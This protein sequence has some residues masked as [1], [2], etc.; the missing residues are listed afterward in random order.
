LEPTL[1]VIGLNHRTAPV[2]MR[3]RFW[4]SE[5]RRYE[6]LRQLKSA[7][8]IEEVVVLSTRCRTEFWLWASDATLA[9]NSLLHFLSLEQGL[10]LSEWEHFYRLLDESALSHC[11]RVVCGLDSIALGDLQIVTQV[12]AA[13]EQARTVGASGRF[14]NA[15]LEKAFCVARQVRSETAIAG[16]AVSI[17]TAALDLA[18]NIFGSLEG[19]NVLLL[20]T[21]EMSELSVRQ[22]VERGVG[23][24]VVIDP[25][26]VRAQKL[27]EK[28]GGTAATPA[29]RW[30][31]MLSADIVL[32]T[33][34]CSHM[35]L[36]REEAER[37]AAERNRLA[38]IIL[39]IGMPRN[40]DPEV[41]W[42]GGMLLYDLDSLDR[43]V[44]D[45]SSERIMADNQADKIIAAE[46]QAFHGHLQTESAVPTIVALR[47]RLD[48]IC[49][50]ELESFIAE[51]GPFNREQDQSL[52]AITTQVIQKI[53][54]SLAHELRELPEKEEQEH[55]NA[56]VARLFHLDSPQRA[57][58]GATSER[59]QNE[60]CEEHAATISH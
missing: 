45:D 36:T 59:Q 58:A 29:E 16:L 3:E 4:I 39:D 37:I 57:L 28:L 19:R 51:H 9:E 47:R 21:S 13:W 40:V 34:G 35:I 55:M 31:C 11:F 27:A 25:S 6:V 49:R 1:L 8:G 38:L 60:Q 14:L 32:C 10:K 17:P 54:N 5:N 26:P 41:S 20:G 23:S 50:Q 43:A 22:M 2:A 52:R 53:A 15:V 42:V 24:V 33:S 56:A 48:Q 46:A 30:Q 7:E 12:D 18:R 44:R